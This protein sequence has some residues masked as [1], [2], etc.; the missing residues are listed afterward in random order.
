MTYSEKLKDPRWQKKRLEILDRDGWACRECGNAE[1]TLHVHHTQYAERTDP[2]DYQD[3]CYVVLCDICH[4]EEHRQIVW[5][6]KFIVNILT[7]NGAVASDLNAIGWFGHFL[8]CTVGSMK[9]TTSF[10]EWLTSDDG[11]G[12][13]NNAILKYKEHCNED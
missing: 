4:K 5:Q 3:T 6:K 12:S 11:F 2:W 13:L 9:E 8:Q 10:L 1:R 7:F